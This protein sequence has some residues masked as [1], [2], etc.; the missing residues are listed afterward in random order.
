MNGLRI[1][2]TCLIFSLLLL[3][4][5]LFSQQVVIN[6]IMNAPSG[7]EPEWIEILNF[8]SEPINL[9]NWKISNRLT[10]TKYTITT[11]D[12][13]LQPDSYAVITRSDTIYYFHSLIPSKVFIVPQIPSARFRNDS[14]AVVLFDSSNTVID[15]VYYKS[16]WVR[17]G[18]SIER[19]YPNRNS[20]L[21]S[22]WGISK[23]SE[24]STPG[25]KNSIMAKAIDLMVKDIAISPEQIFQGQNFNVKS[26][27]Y[28]IGI[29]SV[30]EFSAN[31]F[32][33]LNGDSIFQK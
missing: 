6:E 28:N 12:Y 14:D 21:K 3:T 22:T 33:D 26:T 23:D 32:I 24:R 1:N 5:A 15:S 31:F 13:I 10:T 30:G 9:K 4:S 29:F 7:G 25:R 17:V 2:K 19:I 20:N 8:S 16:D 11:E 27:I 18:Y